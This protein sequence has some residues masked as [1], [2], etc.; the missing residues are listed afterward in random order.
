MDE[1]NNIGSRDSRD[2]AEA[3][4]ERQAGDVADQLGALREQRIDD[5]LRLVLNM[6]DPLRANL[7]AIKADMMTFAHHMRRIIVPALETLAPEP[8]ALGK[9]V[10]AVESHTRVARQVERLTALEERL[11]RQ[12]EEARQATADLEAKP[13]EEATPPGMHADQ[14]A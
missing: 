4:A 11:D 13:H 9:V 14:R 1:K 8:G 12:H 6:H 3:A 10:P 7:G 5:Y 2:S